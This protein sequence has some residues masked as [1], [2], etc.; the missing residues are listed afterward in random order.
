M[1]NP[2]HNGGIMMFLAEFL[3]STFT[4]AILIMLALIVLAGRF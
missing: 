4:N 1:D 3:S 2:E